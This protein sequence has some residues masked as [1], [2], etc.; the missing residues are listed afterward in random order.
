MWM[1]HTIKSKNSPQDAIYAQD[2]ISFDLCWHLLLALQYFGW[3][4]EKPLSIPQLQQ[5]QP[6]TV[7]V[8]LATASLGV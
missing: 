4:R 2:Q 7:S 1:N 8:T 3:V 6:D 5:N